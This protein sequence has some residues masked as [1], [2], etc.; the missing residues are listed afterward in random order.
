METCNKEACSESSPSS[1]AETLTAYTAYCNGISETNEEETFNTESSNIFN[2]KVSNSLRK[3]IFTSLAQTS[4][5][6][7]ANFECRT[8]PSFLRILQEISG[9]CRRRLSYG[10]LTIFQVKDKDFSK[11]LEFMPVIFEKAS[12]LSF[13]FIELEPFCSSK[14]W[15]VLL[16]HF[17][18]LQSLKSFSMESRSISSEQLL[19]LFESL[20]NLC[21]SF[22]YATLQRPWLKANFADVIQFC[23]RKKIELKVQFYELSLHLQ[24]VGAMPFTPVWETSLTSLDTIRHCI[25]PDG[26]EYLCEA[27]RGNTTLTHLDIGYNNI[28]TEGAKYLSEAL[29]K[30]T[31]LTSLYIHENNIGTEGAKYLSDM[32]RKNTTLA[33]LDISLNRIDTEG[34]KCLSE[35]LR[36][37]TTLTSLDMGYSNIDRDGA[38]HLSEALRENTTLTSLDIRDNDIGTDGAKYLSEALRENETLT[39]LDICESYIGAMGSVGAKFVA[40]IHYHIKKNILERDNENVSNAFPVTAPFANDALNSNLQC[41]KNSLEHLASLDKTLVSYHDTPF[42]ERA[43]LFILYMHSR[44]MEMYFAASTSFPLYAPLKRMNSFIADDSKRID[45]RKNPN[46]FEPNHFICAICSDICTCPYCSQ[47]CCHVFCK[48]CIQPWKE[49]NCPTCRT[50]C[51]KRRPSPLAEFLI[52][53]L[54]LDCPVGCSWQS[55]YGD[56]EKSHLLQCPNVVGKCSLCRLQMKQLDFDSHDGKCT[57]HLVSCDYCHDVIPSL[58]LAAHVAHECILA[59]STC[60]ACGRQFLTWQ[61]M[62]RHVE[63]ECVQDVDT[64]RTCDHGCLEYIETS[65]LQQQ[66]SITQHLYLSKETTPARMMTGKKRKVKHSSDNEEQTTV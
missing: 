49:Q 16:K 64:C 42:K 45:V 41:K 6:D 65:L 5:V 62:I 63:E 66:E 36:E 43:L 34:T 3:S 54:R 17:G 31:T 53:H 19:S 30:N 29:Q 7:A 58:L 8:H 46:Y 61:S 40:E 57:Y 13:L 33:H 27:L 50:V 26:A 51:K 9:T 44:R 2:F 23:Q 14:K 22:I 1:K 11:I 55:A 20:N 10:V 4:P 47:N 56:Y 18:T 37:N 59:P 32:L 15:N 12:H 25:G 24:A 60:N 39:S 52:L 21:T 38:K 28:G 35:V 48:T